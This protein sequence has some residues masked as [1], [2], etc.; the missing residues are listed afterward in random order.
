MG[1]F[2]DLIAAGDGA[3]ADALQ[4]ILDLALA[5]VPDAVEGVSYGVPALR[6]RG[7]PLIGVRAAAEHL[8]LFPFSAEVVAAV[9][10]R[11]SGYSLSKGTIRFTAAQ[12][13]PDDVIAR[14]VALR[15]AE[16]ER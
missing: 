15:R 8:S 13:V 1:E 2:S 14:I 12:P 9:A 16:I 6:Y 7:K 3:T 4:R 11:L 10:D 5:E